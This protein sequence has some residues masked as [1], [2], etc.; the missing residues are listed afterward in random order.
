[1]GGNLVISSPVKEQHVGNY[2]CLAANAFGAVVS[3]E[4]SVQFGCRWHRCEPLP[5]AAPRRLQWC[6]VELTERLFGALVHAYESHWNCKGSWEKS[7]KGWM[8]GVHQLAVATTKTAPVKCFCGHFTQSWYM[9]IKEI[10]EWVRVMV[11]HQ[12]VFSS[13][14]LSVSFRPWPFL[15]WGEGGSVCKRRTGSCAA[16]CPPTTLSW[17]VWPLPILYYFLVICYFLVFS[18]VI[19][20]RKHKLFP[21]AKIPLYSFSMISFKFF[22]FFYALLCLRVNTNLNSGILKLQLQ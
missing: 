17:S 4:A 2:S 11:E 12:M 8:V 20:Q 15:I 13:V 3:R 16:V 18:T 19:F 7:Q 6:G 5:P 22:T 10:K 9:E 14:D 1:M 21:P